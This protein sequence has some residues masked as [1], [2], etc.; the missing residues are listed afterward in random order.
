MCIRGGV[1]TSTPGGGATTPRRSLTA[2]EQA[3]APLPAVER[4]LRQAFAAT[5]GAAGEA[6]LFP[7]LQRAAPLDLAST[8]DQGELRGASSLTSVPPFEEGLIGL[9]QAAIK[10][11][12]AGR[13]LSIALGPRKNSTKIA[14]SMM[15]S[16]ARFAAMESRKRKSQAAGPAGDERP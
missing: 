7:P 2:I 16:H 5:E 14:P 13:F 12:T 15:T 4:R 10:T 11:R 9:V 6:A 1:P 3:H 8:G